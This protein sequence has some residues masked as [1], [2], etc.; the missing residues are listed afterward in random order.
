MTT[1]TTIADTEV[2]VDSPITQSLMERLRDNPLSIQERDNSAPQIPVQRLQVFTASGTFTVPS[3]VEFV[4][5]I[6]TGGGGGA[7]EVSGANDGVGG[8]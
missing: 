4:E 6:C 1:Y 3:G 5:V 7:E 2:D 8:S